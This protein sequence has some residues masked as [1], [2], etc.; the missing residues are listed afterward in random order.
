MGP[1]WDIYTA[2]GSAKVDPFIITRMGQHMAAA[3]VAREL[4]LR[5]PNTTINTACA[6]GTDALATRSAWS[7]SAM[8]MRC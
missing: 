1:Q 5:G 2:R 6:S 8:P 7:G 4:G 3:R